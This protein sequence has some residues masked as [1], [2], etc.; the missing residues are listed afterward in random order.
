MSDA[1]RE[2]LVAPFKSLSKGSGLPAIATGVTAIAMDQNNAENR[3]CE[4]T[5][6]PNSGSPMTGRLILDHPSRGAWNMAVDEA[7]MLTAAD[8]GVPT[9]RFYRWQEPTVSLGYFQT[10]Q[11][12]FLH[13]ESL[14]AALVRRNSGGG[15]IVHDKELTYSL[16]VPTAHPLGNKPCAIYKLMHDTLIESLDAI[17]ISA[18]LNAEPVPELESKFL[19]FQRRAS[20]DILFHGNKVCGSAQRKRHQAISQHGSFILN[21]SPAAPQISGIND[22]SGEFIEPEPLIKLWTERLEKRTGIL[23]QQDTL[24][25]DE[26]V[27]STLIEKGKFSTVNWSQ[28]R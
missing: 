28:R 8:L 10:Y 16:T 6:L 20:N 7:L 26:A 25:A 27:Q 22:L 14:D 5:I 24:S 13:P 19:C 18:E 23:F 2:C 15:A 12:R 17:G 11:E 3:I 21:T 9:L 1:V 4:K